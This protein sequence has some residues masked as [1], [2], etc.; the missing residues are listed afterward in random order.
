MDSDTEVENIFTKRKDEEK[1]NRPPSSYGSM[2]SDSDDLEETTVEEGEEVEVAVLPEPPTRA[3][4]GM[5]MFRCASPET[6]YTI[7]TEQTKP[8]G[9]LVIETRSSDLEGLSD[10]DD[11]DEDEDEPLLTHS[12]E[13]PEPLELEDSMQTNENNQPGKLHPM[14]DLP[15]IFKTIQSALTGLTKGELLSFKMRFYHWERKLTL[16]QAM[17]GDLLDFVDKTIELLGLD[18]AL[19]QTIETLRN[20]DK[21]AEAN[22]LH[23]KCQRA[24]VRF[25]MNNNLRSK[26]R[27][28]HEGIVQAG[29]QSFLNK[30]YV[31][32]QISTCSYGGVYPSHELRPHPPTP[33]QVPGPDTFVSVNNLFR[34]LKDDGTPVRTVVTTGLAGVGMSLCVARF[35]MD[36]AEF[37]ANRDLQFVISLSFQ[38]LWILRTRTDPP[39]DMS[40]CNVLEYFLPDLKCLKYLQEESSNFLLIMDSYDQYQAPLDWKNAPVINDINTPVHLDVLTVNILRGNLIEGARKWILGRQAAVSQIPSKF[41]DIVTEI[42]GFSDEMKDEYM[43]KRF[44]EGRQAEKIIRH[45]KRSPTLDILARHPFVCWIVSAMYGG[46]LRSDDYGTHP[47]RLT[48]FLT[49]VMIIQ[50]NRRLEFYYGQPQHSLKWSTK[51]C[52]LLM[53]MGKMAFKMMERKTS[54]FFEEDVK[55]VG[56][57]LWEVVVSSGL[58]SELHTTASDCRRKFSFIHYTLQ[59]F[60]AALYVFMM[61]HKESKNVLDAYSDLKPKFLTNTSAE[62]LVQ[63]ALALTLSS[64]LGLYDMFLRLLCGLM[65]PDCHFSLLRGYFYPHSYPKVAKLDEVQRLLEQ[66]IRKAPEN[67]VENLKECLRELIQSDD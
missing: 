32:P 26:H 44:T 33:V 64:P 62:V 20:I 53:G 48:L 35:S 51:D 23:D 18:H 66:S 22:E 40:F 36:W 24:L 7:G 27:I 60:I 56:L 10:M 4:T 9:A 1:L 37:R 21:V 2:K 54:V 58:C 15:H 41:I 59:E 34:L 38:S 42:Q 52:N 13:P 5:Q 43:T 31:E 39:E 45:Y 29:K 16:Q 46:L 14:Q 55:K 57:P 12:P 30:V 65:S 49:E 8:P 63:N 19:S 25:Q 61:F 67:R 47:P 17:E 28:I 11:Q 3:V 6:L 50:M